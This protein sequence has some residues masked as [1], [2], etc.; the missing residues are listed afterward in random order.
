LTHLSSAFPTTFADFDKENAQSWPESTGGAVTIQIA[1]EVGALWLLPTA[2]YDASETIDAFTAL[3]SVDQTSFL[4]AFLAQ[5]DSCVR[6][7]LRF[8]Y[9]PPTIEGCTNGFQ[10]ALTRLRAFK[11]VRDDLGAYSGIPMGIWTEHD[12]GRL[13]DLCSTCLASLKSTH[14]NARRTFFDNL[15]QMYGLPS[16]AELSKIK[17]AALTE[18]VDEA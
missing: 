13:S 14:R 17:T 5:R 4:P 7:I 2:F 18:P 3:E 12:W 6:D 11:Y 8:L 1:R 16:W 10:C 15:P 9:E